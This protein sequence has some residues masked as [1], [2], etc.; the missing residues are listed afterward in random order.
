MK[1]RIQFAS[2]HGIPPLGGETGPIAQSRNPGTEHHSCVPPIN[3]G[4][5]CQNPPPVVHPTD[6]SVIKAARAVWA[7]VTLWAATSLTLAAA[8]SFDLSTARLAVGPAAN[9]WL[10]FADGS[11]WPASDQPALAL[12]T[13]GATHLVESAEL[14][15]DTLAVRFA[16]G[17]RAEF[18]VTRHRGFAVFR[19]ARL[20]APQPVTRFRMFQLAAP[21]QARIYGT[22]NGAALDGNFAAVMA[23]KPNV[24]A[25]NE[26]AGGA[27]ADRAGC[28]HEF[29]QTAP[30]KAGAHTA[31]FTATCGAQPGGWSMRGRNFVAP[32]DLSGCRAIRAWVHGDGRG[33]ALKIQ[34]Y[35]GAGGYRD[36]YIAIDFQ[37]WRQVTLTNCPINSLRYNRV[38]EL[39]F[40]YN[41]LPA[42]T[43]VTCLVDHVEA[44]IEREG[45]TRVL[46]LEDFENAASPLWSP[47]VMNLR[48]ETEQAH[49]LEPA[50]FGVIACREAD[51]LETVERFEVAAGLPSPRPG[52]VW[53]KQSPWVKRSYFF[54]TD[55]RESQF[56]DALALARR[57]GFHTI[58]LDQDSWCR[59]TGHYEVNRERFPNGLE[60]LKR[61]LW[62]FK[63][64]GFRV[65]LHLLGASIYPPDSYL[66]PVPDPRLVKGAAATLAA[67]VSAT[68]NFLPL[69]AAPERFPAEDGGCE[70]QGTVLQIGEEL[71]QYGSRALQP[72]FGFRDCQRGHLGTRPAAHKQGE[73]VRHLVRAYGYHMHDMDT[74]L[75]DEVAAHFARVANTCGIDM[76]YFDGSEQLQGE[77]WYYNAR[78]VQA[79]YDKLANKNLLLQASSFSHYSWHLLARS[80]SADGHGDLKGYLDQRSGWFGSFARDGMPL[81]IGWYYGYDPATTP[82]MFEYVLG[83]TIG[84]DSS[85]SFQ[86][87]CGAAAAHPFTGEILDLIAR[88]EQLRLSGRVPEALK[89]RLRIDPALTAIKPGEA[90]P[91]LL[92][93]RREYR[94]LEENGK[95]FFQRVEYEPW[96]EIKPGGTNAAAWRVRVQDG[97]ARVGVQIHAPRGAELVNPFIEL[98]GRRWS[99]DGKLSEGQFLLFWPGEPVARYG[100]PLKNPERAAAAPSFTLPPGEYSATFGSS[101]AFKVPVR[102][103]ITL[104]SPER[105]NF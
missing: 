84:Y 3:D 91:D 76:I 89:T 58:V 20:T 35:D 101:N 22:V 94:L 45:A 15:G 71:I 18:Q 27:R 9:A 86:V 12:E 57:G 88:Y 98:G 83:A 63:E 105:I 75:L 29:V 7:V 80:A 28:D 48:V 77:H 53:N 66:T 42:N 52:G 41:G 11:R 61:T 25:F 67:D 16:N 55:F 99:W 36:N 100:L 2:G 44:L 6:F 37:G 54:L 69:A 31:R 33:E 103:R 82:D 56:D 70:G 40:Y 34:L 24:H 62:R 21:V 43:T 104:Q 10:E 23:A 97:P 38:T 17:A 60:G 85:M 78:L 39:S 46:V 65:G 64:A 102:V 90:Q 87:S 51:F 92:E 50:A 4:T 59:G 68:T 26:Q 19:L 30:G 79:F 96:H 72:P 49:G 81:D 8:V 74:S 32:L 1:T 13:A 95:P 47:P 93:K 5:P 14:S 73:A